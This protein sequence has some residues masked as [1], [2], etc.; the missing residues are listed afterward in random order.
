MTTQWK[1]ISKSSS[2]LIKL[3]PYNVMMILAKINVN[4]LMDGLR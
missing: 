3:I 2:T 4:N 1:M